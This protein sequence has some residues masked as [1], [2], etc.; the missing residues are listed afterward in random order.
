MGDNRKGTGCSK[1]GDFSIM[2]PLYINK[3]LYCL[4]E[5]R[6]SLILK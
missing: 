3:K 1:E 6:V 5:L 2:N 4:M